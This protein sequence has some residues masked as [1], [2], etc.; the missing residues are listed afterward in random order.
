MVDDVQHQ[1]FGGFKEETEFWIGFE[2]F[3]INGLLEGLQ[4]SN[5]K[6]GEKN[7]VILSFY[8]QPHIAVGASEFLCDLLLSVT[9][10]S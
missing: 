4:R 9:H 2:E 1:F 7:G 8:F 6:D 3:A 5:V 10:S